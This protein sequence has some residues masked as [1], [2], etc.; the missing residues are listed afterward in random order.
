[1]ERSEKKIKRKEDYT[2]EKKRSEVRKR[3]E[4]SISIVH[5]KEFETSLF[6]GKQLMSPFADLGEQQS[7]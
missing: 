4:K 3:E 1:M 5:D 6:L 7:L 2:R